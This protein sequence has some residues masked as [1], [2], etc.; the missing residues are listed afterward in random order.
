[1]TRGNE[2]DSQRKRIR[3]LLAQRTKDIASEVARADGR[4]TD[5]EFEALNRLARLA[6]IQD[7]AHSRSRPRWPV[8]ATFAGTLVILSVLLFARV[9]QTDI[10]L[11]VVASGISFVLPSQQKLVDALTVIRLGGAGLRDVELPRS[12]DRAAHAIHSEES[13]TALQI[14]SGD[15]SS[16][17]LDALILPAGTVVSV[18]HA[19]H[20]YQYRLMLERAQPDVR[21]AVLG[22]VNVRVSGAGR[23][24][25]HFNAPSEV[26]LRFGDAEIDLNV[27]LP[28]AS[29]MTLAPQLAVSQLAFSEIDEAADLARTVVRRVSTITSGTLYLESLNGETRLLRAGDDIKFGCSEGILR[30]VQFGESSIVVKFHGRVSG[31]TLG[32][33]N[34]R[35]SL[36]PTWL[37]WLR[38]R[39]SLSL[40][41]AATLYV[42]GLVTAAFRWFGR[43]L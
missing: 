15:N 26:L 27:G 42:F 32:S 19:E 18:R 21:L 4:I 38:A 9:P 6:E 39:H 24:Q 13:D 17:N 29:A 43:P 41:W 8:I 33:G 11:D 5:E 35:R 16:L 3:A 40:F 31:M 7:E 20:P 37:E 23:Q 14:S 10:E 25:F 30:T 12:R 34:N 22:S 2:L 28:K 1:M 36:M